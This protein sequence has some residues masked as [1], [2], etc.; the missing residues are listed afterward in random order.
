MYSL[1]HA[2]TTLIHTI[3]TYI[4]S[5][6][7]ATTTYISPQ[8][9]YYHNIHADHHN[10][11]SCHHNTHAYTLSQHTNICMNHHNI[12][13][14][15]RA[16]K[17][18]ETTPRCKTTESGHESGTRPRNTFGGDYPACKH[19]VTFKVPVTPSPLKPQNVPPRVPHCHWCW[20]LIVHNNT[21]R[22]EFKRQRR[23]LSCSSNFATITVTKHCIYIV[24][25]WGV[26]VPPQ[27]SVTVSVSV[28]VHS[29]KRTAVPRRVISFPLR[30]TSS[31]S[32]LQFNRHTFF[33][34]DIC[35]H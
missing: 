35:S 10:K 14:Y 6:M 8:H 22:T 25:F 9:T 7:H 33:F 3:T 23:T 26:P 18:P 17:G 19:I 12:Q 28:C 16:Q 4:L 29:L 27:I 13:T 5:C 24:N 32:V 34:S 2:I 1:I 30:F 15:M 21:N 11:H 20:L 31:S